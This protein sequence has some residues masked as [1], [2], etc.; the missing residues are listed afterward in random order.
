M[1]T[2]AAAASPASAPA[3]APSAAEAQ[4]APRKAAGPAAQAPQGASQKLEVLLCGPAD[5][6]FP[7][8]SIFGIFQLIML[9]LVSSHCRR[10]NKQQC[11]AFAQ[12]PP[13]SVRIA[14]SA[15]EGLP[16]E[17]AGRQADLGGGLPAAL[18]HLLPAR[19]YAGGRHAFS[20]P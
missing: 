17:A 10:K 5:H 15:L 6:P 11:C 13:A 16:A 12:A 14:A 18:Q 4:E 9:C 20:S 8:Q 2:D 1:Q 19:L 7:C 3:A